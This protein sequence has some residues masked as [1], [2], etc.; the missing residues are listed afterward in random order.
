MSAFKDM[1]ERDITTVFL[2]AD[3]F[4]EIHNLNGTDCVCVISTEQT[5]DR[6]AFLQGVKRTPDGLHGDYIT[7]CVKISDLESVPK[8]GTNFKVDGKRYTVD[9]C[10]SD[11]GMLTIVLG[12]YRMRG[13][14]Q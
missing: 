8:Q 13:G 14:L 10:T 7:I 2:N 3:E 11:M 4:A 1:I 6:R 5:D 9:S 12:A